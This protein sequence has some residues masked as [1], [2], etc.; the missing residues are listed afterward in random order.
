MQFCNL[1]S[2]TKAA[3]LTVYELQHYYFL[4]NFF[5]PSLWLNSWDPDCATCI[6]SASLSRILSPGTAQ[7]QVRIQVQTPADGVG[8]PD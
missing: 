2:L 1:L 8:K 3:A 5:F 6:H 4:E 7:A